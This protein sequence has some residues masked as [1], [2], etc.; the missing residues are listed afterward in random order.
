MTSLVVFIG[1]MVALMVGGCMLGCWY[2]SKDIKEQ[3]NNEFKRYK[4]DECLELIHHRLKFMDG[5]Q[6]EI[7]MAH[8][9]E[10]AGH[11]VYLTSA[12]RDGGIDL[13]L[14]DTIAVELKNYGCKSSIGTP[15][16]QKLVGASVS[17][18]YSHAMIITRDGKYTKDAKNI[19]RTC[20]AVEIDMWDIGNILDLCCTV[21]L[22]GVLK[23][24]DLEKVA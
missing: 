6:F 17:G 14:D 3:V 9:F 15:I 2:M 10:Q 12:T 18:G 5:R 7:F 21:G 20:K 13:L 19:I 16:V 4:R 8:L 24:L 11:K 1:G 23:Y 22:V